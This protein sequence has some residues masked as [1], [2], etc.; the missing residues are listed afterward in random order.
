M[1]KYIL[2]LIPPD[3]FPNWFKPKPFTFFDFIY[4]SFYYSIT[5]A[6]ILLYIYFRHGLLT[7][8]DLFSKTVDS[9]KEDIKSN[10]SVDSVDST[11]STYSSNSSANIIAEYEKRIRELNEKSEKYSKTIDELNKKLKEPK[12]ISGTYLEEIS[13]TFISEEMV[14]QEMENRS[15][16]REVSDLQIK[17]AVIDEIKKNASQGESNDDGMRYLRSELEKV[18][19]C[20]YPTIYTYV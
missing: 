4:I 10:D 6:A 20:V 19:E 7:K 5:V 3:L 9:K 17:L 1:L 11:Y 18:K 12:S 15:L 16:R 14:K 8:I 13:E 2:Y